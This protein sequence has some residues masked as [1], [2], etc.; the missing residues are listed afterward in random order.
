MVN[1]VI[2]F[3]LGLLWFSITIKYVKKLDNR[4]GLSKEE[5]SIILAVIFISVLSSV[6]CTLLLQ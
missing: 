5:T 1:F 3:V 4:F 2:L 6:A